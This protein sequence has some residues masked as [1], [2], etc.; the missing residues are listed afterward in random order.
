MD[1][2]LPVRL[3][4]VLLLLPIGLVVGEIVDKPEVIPVI[5]MFGGLII[6]LVGFVIYYTT[7]KYGSFLILDAP[8]LLDRNRQP[9]L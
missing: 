7:K 3:S 8:K 6:L 9:G 4:C 5:V 2:A 1:V